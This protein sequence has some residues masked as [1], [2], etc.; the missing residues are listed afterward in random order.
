MDFQLAKAAAERDLLFLGQMLV[1]EKHDDVVVEMP[2]QLGEGRIVDRPRQ[3]EYDL[4]AARG[5]GFTDWHRHWDHLWN[6]PACFWLPTF[7]DCIRDK[8]FE[9]PAAP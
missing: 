5:A 6:Y 1:A 8:L 9:W 7:S 3:V 2:L 4:G